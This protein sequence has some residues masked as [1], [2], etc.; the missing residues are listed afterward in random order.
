MEINNCEKC[1]SSYE[2]YNNQKSAEYW[3]VAPQSELING[4]WFVKKPKG[5][6]QFCNPK[7]KYYLNGAKPKTNTKTI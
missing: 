6:C 4:E 5:V 7:S 1:S 3:C 2:N